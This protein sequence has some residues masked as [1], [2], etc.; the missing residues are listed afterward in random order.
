[1]QNYLYM[2]IN[3]FS[4]LPTI[5]LSFDKKVAF[6][7]KWKYLFPS[8]VIVSIPFLIWDELFTQSGVWGFNPRYLSGIYLFSL[9][10][11]EVMFFFSIPYACVFTYE[12]LKVYI[13][14]EIVNKEKSKIVSGIFI[15]SLGILSILFYRK[16]YTSITFISLITFVAIFQY[17]L[18]FKEMGKFYFSY[19]IIIIPFLIV[20]G[21]LTGSFLEEPVVWYNNNENLAIRLF[22]IPVE[23]IFYGM[24]LI[25]LNVFLFET[26]QRKKVKN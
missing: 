22:T 11:E 2:L 19:S 10:I 4:V 25:L 3:I 12:V 26:F 14:K 9:P 21:I 1:M 5:A 20:N 8:I 24:L 6:Y 13:K 16:V 17:F 18:R 7:K 23:D 15:L